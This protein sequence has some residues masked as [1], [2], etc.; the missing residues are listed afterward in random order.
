MINP[1]RDNIILMKIT[2][3]LNINIFSE[4]NGSF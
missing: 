3:F 1:L 4:K 2:V